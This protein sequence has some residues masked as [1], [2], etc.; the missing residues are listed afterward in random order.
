MAHHEFQC[1]V[2]VQPLA[3]APPPEDGQAGYAY[4]YTITITNKGEVPAQLVAREWTITDARGGV[5]EVRGL[6]VVGHQPLLQPGESF[7]YSSWAQI[8]TPQGSMRGRYLCVSEDAQVFYADIP[9][10]MLADT[11]HLH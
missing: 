7:R 1:S 4:S 5:Q 8:A 10:F 9:E 3:D 11:S 6:A 2:H